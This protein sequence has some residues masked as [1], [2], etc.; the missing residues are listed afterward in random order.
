MLVSVKHDFENKSELAYADP[1]VQPIRQSLP[2]S[3]YRDEIVS[4]IE[5]HQVVV[6]CGETGW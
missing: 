6:L 1:V 2:I 5:G 4:T 3:A